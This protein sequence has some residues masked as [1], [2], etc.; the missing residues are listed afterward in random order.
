VGVLVH[1][2]DRAPRRDA[3][4][5]VE[6]R[7]ESHFSL[8]LRADLQHRIAPVRWHAQ[9]LGNERQLA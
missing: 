6:K 1:H 4:E 7:G 3:V 8:L 9:E 2:Q 5:L